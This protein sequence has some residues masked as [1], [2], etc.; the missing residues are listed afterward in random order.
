MHIV[1]LQELVLRC[2]AQEPPAPQHPN[3]NHRS[4]L[5]GA[6]HPNARSDLLLGRK[7]DPIALHAADP[8]DE[9]LRVADGAALAV[10]QILQGRW[11][12]EGHHLPAPGGVEVPTDTLH[13]QQVARLPRAQ[14]TGHLGKRARRQVFLSKAD[15]DGGRH[16]LGRD[17]A[18]ADE[19]AAD[20]ARRQGE[21]RE[22]D[23]REQGGRVVH[24]RGQQRRELQEWDLPPSHTLKLREPA[25]ALLLVVPHL[26]RPLPLEL[27][28]QAVHGLELDVH[29]GPAGTPSAP[30]R[31]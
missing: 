9:V 28:G 7:H 31:P 20:P 26:H 14:A 1:G 11:R 18:E 3:G 13:H 22:G 24:G 15:L 23:G 19:G 10:H 27:G 29:L 8:L 12:L 4:G 5:V 21:R 17:V 6:R 25:L 30:L 16:G 2:L